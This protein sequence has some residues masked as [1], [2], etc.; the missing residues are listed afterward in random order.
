MKKRKMPE[1]VEMKTEEHQSASRPFLVWYAL[2]WFLLLIALAF[3]MRL[4]PQD[5]NTEVTKQQVLSQRSTFQL[6]NTD[7][8]SYIGL[9]TYLA[10]IEE[11]TVIFMDVLGQVQQTY[12]IPFREAE[13]TGSG[14]K[15]FIK[16][17]LSLNLIMFQPQS[18]AI[19]FETDS[20]V[21]N[22][23]AAP[24]RLLL[25]QKST[26]SLG[27]LN[28]YDKNQSQ[29]LLTLSFFES[30]YPLDMTFHADGKSFDLSLINVNQAQPCTVLQRYNEW[31]EKVSEMFLPESELLPGIYLLN[32]QCTALFNNEKVFLVDITKQEILYQA[33][34]NKITD[35]AVATNSLLLLADKS[36][37]LELQILRESAE[38]FSFEPVDDFY[39]T[40]GE[41]ILANSPETIFLAQDKLLRAYE[42]SSGTLVAESELDESA[43]N[44]IVQDNHTLLVLTEQNGYLYSLD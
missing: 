38:S 28:V 23:E 34:F 11:G 24:D 33:S 10:R 1:Y 35:L 5:I 36:D 44:L 17:D 30:G 16:S 7:P 26:D 31:G 21:E 8:L 6:M 25:L 19:I 4:P 41:I 18:E 20:I 32:E 42:I 14:G 29:A 3:V 2:A 40:D 27:E 43:V 39:K 12:E 15:L 22:I 9:G 13:I 37:K